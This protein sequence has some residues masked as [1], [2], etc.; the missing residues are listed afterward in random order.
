MHSYLQL[1][2]FCLSKIYSYYFKYIFCLT[3][4]IPF[5]DPFCLPLLCCLTPIYHSPGVLPVTILLQTLLFLVYYLIS[6]TY[7]WIIICYSFLFLVC[8]TFFVCYFEAR[9]QYYRLVLN[10]LC[11]KSGLELLIP[12]PLL[13]K[14][15]HNMYLHACF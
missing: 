7:C 6:S 8:F 15:W 11:S 12:L 10:F 4:T 13:H 5:S 9:S 2:R 1:N 14:Y 3:M